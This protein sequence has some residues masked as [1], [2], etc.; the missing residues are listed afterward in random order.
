M[1][2]KID[3][4]HADYGFSSSLVYSVHR[5][6][7]GQFHIVSHASQIEGQ[8]TLLLLDP[9]TPELSKYSARTSA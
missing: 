4:R 9:P 2:F 5:D 6:G 1:R 7:D 8:P 3:S